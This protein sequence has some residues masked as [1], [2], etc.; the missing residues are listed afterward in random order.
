MRILSD[1]EIAERGPI[2]ITSAVQFPGKPPVHGKISASMGR[3]DSPA[4]APAP[5]AAAAAPG[6]DG[7]QVEGETFCAKVHDLT[8]KRNLSRSEAIKTAAAENP[9]LHERHIDRINAQADG[10]AFGWSYVKKENVKTFAE[11]VNYELS[12]GL[13]P[14]AAVAAAARDFPELFEQRRRKL[15]KLLK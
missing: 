1:K 8:I 14:R 9:A 3:P 2:F 13:D 12:Q 7:A 5:R 4:P 15:A 6:G 11:A 10:D